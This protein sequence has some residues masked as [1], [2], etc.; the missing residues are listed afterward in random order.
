MAVDLCSRVSNKRD[1]RIAR[2]IDAS[3]LD[4]GLMVAPHN[5]YNPALLLQSEHMVR[6][7]TTFHAAVE[8]AFA[9]VKVNKHPVKL[10]EMKSIN[11][12]GGEDIVCFEDQHGRVGA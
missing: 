2:Y 12:R 6:N 5:I 7:E 9:I 10:I 3:L 8:Q 11:Y 1:K 4:A